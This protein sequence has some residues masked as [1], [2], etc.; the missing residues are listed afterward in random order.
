MDVIESL[1]EK[2][3][4]TSEGEFEITTKDGEKRIWDFKSANIGELSD[5]RNLVISLATD[6]T[7]RKKDNHK[8]RWRRRPSSYSHN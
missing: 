7:K 5:G 2:R 8:R 1:H 6:I 4:K 3:R